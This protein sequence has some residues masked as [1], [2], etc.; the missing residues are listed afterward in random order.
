M[1][2]GYVFKRGN[3]W[4][5]DVYDGKDKPV[6]MDNTGNWRIIFDSCFFG[7]AAVRRIESAGHRLKYSYPQLVEKAGRS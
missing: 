1:S 7:T 5:Y 4:Y 6:L 2:K 3:C